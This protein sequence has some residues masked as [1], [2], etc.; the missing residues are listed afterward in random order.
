MID[1]T[2]IIIRLLAGYVFC[3]TLMGIAAYVCWKLTK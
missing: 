2:H 1:P 3:G